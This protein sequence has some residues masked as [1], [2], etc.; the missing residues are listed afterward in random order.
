VPDAIMLA[1]AGEHVASIAGRS[2]IARV[3]RCAGPGISVAPHK[4]IM[5]VERDPYTPA[6]W[7]S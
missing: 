6:G 4:F 5:K 2:D 7:P 3:N 1:G